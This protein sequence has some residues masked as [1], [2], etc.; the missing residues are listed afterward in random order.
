MGM[1]CRPGGRGTAAGVGI[2]FPR[3]VEGWAKPERQEASGSD[4]MNTE[5]ATHWHHA[6]NWS[7]SKVETNSASSREGTL[8]DLEDGCEWTERIQPANAT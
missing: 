5:P 7:S 1:S 8:G 6:V 3:R 2:G 4:S